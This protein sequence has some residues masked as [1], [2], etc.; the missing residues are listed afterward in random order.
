M[1]RVAGGLNDQPHDDH[2]PG[3]AEDSELDMQLEGTCKQKYPYILRNF[4][5]F[6]IFTHL[7]TKQYIKTIL[8][9]LRN[10][11][12]SHHQNN[13]KQVQK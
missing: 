10:L 5:Y 8:R 3:E 13:S 2:D 9:Y 11:K 6:C 7:K 12:I 4:H 1:R